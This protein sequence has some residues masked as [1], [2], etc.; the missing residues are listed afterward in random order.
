M[1]VYVQLLLGNFL[2]KFG[3]GG[4]DGD[5]AMVEWIRRIADFVDGVDDGLLPGR[6]NLIGSETG[7][8]KVKEDWQS[9][10]R[11]KKE[12]VKYFCVRYFSSFLLSV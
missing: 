3:E 8:D 7:V 10:E 6:G 1:Q 4:N 12:E 9:E 2:H 11:I 5:R